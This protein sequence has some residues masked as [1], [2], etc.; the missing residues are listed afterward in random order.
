V[1]VTPLRRTGTPLDV[2][3]VVLFLATELSSYVNGANIVVDG[4]RTAITQGCYED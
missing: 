4:G 1:R 3:R 2:A